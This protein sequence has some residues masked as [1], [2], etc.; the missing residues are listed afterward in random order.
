[1]RVVAN[2]SVRLPELKGSGAQHPKLLKFKSMLETRLPE[3]KHREEWQQFRRVAVAQFGSSVL[4]PKQK[5]EAFRRLNLTP[6]QLRFFAERPGK[7]AD[8]IEK[9]QAKGSFDKEDRPAARASKYARL[10]HKV[11]GDGPVAD[12]R[13]TATFTVA[14]IND[15]FTDRYTNVPDVKATIKLV[16]EAKATNLRGEVDKK[17]WGVHQ[18]LNDTGKKGAAV[19]WNK[20][21]ARAGDRGYAL[22]VTP[23]GRKMETRFISWSDVV[24]DGVKV[25]VASTHRPPA[26]FKALWPAFDRNL[27]QFV[28]STRLPLIIGM[29]SNTRDHRRMESVTGLKWAGPP[30]DIDGFLVSPGIKV[31]QIHEG[32]KRRS[33]HAPVIAR[34]R[35]T[36]PR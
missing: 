7:V 4:L 2:G 32:P 17:D 8:L 31:D 26:R 19:V 28:K 35:V 21:R 23:Q 25:R 15:D 36:Q 33:D 16:Q 3:G 13:K 30:G 27:A 6:A 11:V 34:F 14:S 5:G 9:L 1:M 18:D 29:D 10:A 12:G 20:D 24:I 22:G